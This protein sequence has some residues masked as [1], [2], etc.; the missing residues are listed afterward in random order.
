MADKLPAKK[1]TRDL[2]KLAK[3]YSYFLD[4]PHGRTLIVLAYAPLD[5]AISVMP[6]HVTLEHLKYARN[7]IQGVVFGVGDGYAEILAQLEPASA[8]LGN[9]PSK[10]APSAKQARLGAYCATLERHAI[11]FRE[12][13]EHC[14]DSS[15]EM[16]R[17]V[18]TGAAENLRDILASDHDP[19]F[20]I[21]SPGRVAEALAGIDTS[22]KRKGGQKKGSHASGNTGP[23]HVGAELAVEAEAFGFGQTDDYDKSVAQAKKAVQQAVTRR[24]P[25]E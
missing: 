7:L 19:A 24:K 25:K 10:T 13:R 14:K 3:R 12:L 6:P 17:A 4:T 9:K 2:A 18:L 22:P 1:T 15:A 21:L 23:I 11:A 8:T 5:R 20:G 16:T